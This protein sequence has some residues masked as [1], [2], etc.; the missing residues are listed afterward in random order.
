MDGSCNEE[1][2]PCCRTTG[3]ADG[4]TCKVGVR[5]TGTLFDPGTSCVTGYKEALDFCTGTG[6]FHNAEA[7]VNVGAVNDRVLNRGG[8][9][10]PGDVVPK[11]DDLRSEV[12][13]GSNKPPGW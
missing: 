12:A 10:A 13:H 8:G 2:E 9:R 6:G 11:H 3:M 7:S 4:A 1:P 5:K